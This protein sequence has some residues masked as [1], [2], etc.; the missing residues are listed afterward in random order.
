[1]QAVQDFGYGQLT[2]GP[3]VASFITENPMIASTAQPV[4]LSPA[5]QLAENNA[6]L[7]YLTTQ[8]AAIGT[9]AYTEQEAAMRG[10]DFAKRQGMTL[11]QAGAG[12]GLDEA[13]VR[14][15]ADELGINLASLGFNQGG[16]VNSQDRSPVELRQDAV[17]SRLMRQTGL[18]S[19]QGAT[20][21][22]E[23]SSTLD[24]IMARSK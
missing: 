4:E 15:R 19:I 6:R 22:P 20:M 7:Q 23:I 5:E 24:R 12:F 1:M 3:D 11:D 10:L 17:G 14:A 8:D 16:S 2:G 21:S 18:A 9:G 13:G